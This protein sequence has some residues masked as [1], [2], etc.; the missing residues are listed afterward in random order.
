M[1]YLSLDHY[2][3][4][5][6]L[7]VVLRGQGMSPRRGGF[8]MAKKELKEAMRMIT[9]LLTDPRVDIGQRDQLMS[10]RREL[11]KLAKSGRPERRRLFRAVEKISMVLLEM[12]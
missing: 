11:V 2:L 4:R 3:S 9:K 12:L 7:G 6:F 5:A 1:R 10:A 8:V